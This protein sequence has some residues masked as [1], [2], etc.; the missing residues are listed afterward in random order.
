MKLLVGIGA[1]VVLAIGAFV[2]VG[3]YLLQEDRY[4]R[5]SEGKRGTK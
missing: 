4:R 3:L 2:L 5:R 1:I